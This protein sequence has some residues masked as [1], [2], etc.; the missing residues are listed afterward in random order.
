MDDAKVNVLVSFPYFNKTI[1]KY[2]D[3]LDPACFRLIIDSGAFTAWRQNTEISMQKYMDFLKT[4]PEAWEWRAVQL[5]VYGNPA[6]T[7]ANWQRMLDAG[8][9]DVMPVFTRGDRISRLEEYYETTDYIMFGGIAFGGEN[10]NYIKFFCEANKGRKAHWLGFVNIA[11]LKHYRPESVDSSTQMSTQRYGDM[12]CYRGGGRLKRLVKTDFITELPGDFVRS[13]QQLGF[14]KKELTGLRKAEAWRGGCR[15]PN[16]EVKGL[17]SFVGITHHVWRA[18]TVER[19]LGTKIYLIG[20]DIWC[21]RGMFEAMQF[22]K[23]R[24]HV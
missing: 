6:K 24:V 1:R 9:S 7:Y 3:D 8:Y 10:R 17:A 13:S 2:L 5:D 11:F 14:T 4:I 23:E 16:A 18:L 12:T 20:A 15:W 22:L 21:V 19:Q